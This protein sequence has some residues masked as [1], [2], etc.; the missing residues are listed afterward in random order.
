MTGPSAETAVRCWGC[1]ALTEVAARLLPALYRGCP[2]CGLRFQADRS[3]AELQ[4]LYDAGYFEDYAGGDYSAA[5]RQRDHEAKVRVR[6]LRRF[7]KQPG[8]LVEIGSAG[9]H[10][11][12]R[13]GEHGYRALGVEPVAELAEGARRDLG[14][15]VRVGFLDDVDLAASAYDVACAFHVI[16]HM[17]APLDALRVMRETLR[18]GGLLIVEVPNIESFR[19]RESGASWGALEP[20]HHVSHFGPRALRT[21]MERAGFTVI[22]TETVPF[23]SYLHPRTAAQP[24]HLAH[25]AALSLRARVPLRGTHPDRHEL[26]RAVATPAPE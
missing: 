1:G 8:D 22:G 3:A 21:V 10:F 24:R 7:R 26:L 2:E 4:D 14:V 19:A 13:A 5:F 9:G 20:L 11:L 12:A 25:R 16:E 6:L 18:P 17:T 23:Y 15:E